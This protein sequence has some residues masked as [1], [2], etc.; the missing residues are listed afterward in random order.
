MLI[1]RFTYQE[2]V[3]FVHE[4]WRIH[5]L[6]WQAD[7]LYKF[8]GGGI[9]SYSL[10]TDHGKSMLLEMAAVI[11]NAEDPDRRFILVK[12]ND[13][14]AK[15]VCIEIC[16][17]LE[18]ISTELR[19]N[20]APLYPGSQPQVTWRGGTPWGVSKGFDV[21]GRDFRSRNI[22]P[23]IRSAS[24][25][26][27]DIQGKRGD[28]AV[29]DV[30]RLEEAES[31]AYR[32][33]LKTH[34]EGIFRTLEDKPDALWL[35]VGTPFHGDSIYDYVTRRLDGL[36]VEHER[37]VRP[38]KNEDGSFL[39]EERARKSEI[40]RKLMGKTAYAAAY[41]LRPVTGEPLTKEQVRDLVRDPSLPRI[42]NQ[43]QLVQVLRAWAMQTPVP[44]AFSYQR[45]IDLSLE[46]ELALY[47]C[48]DP[49]T[50]GD[51]ACGTVAIWGEDIFVLRGQVSV[52]DTWDQLLAVEDCYLPFPSSE[53]VVE[54]NGQQKAFKELAEQN[55]GLSKTQIH[56]HGTGSNKHD[57]R[58]G[59]PALIATVKQGFLHCSWADPAWAELEYDDLEEELISYGATSHPH[60]LMAIWFAWRRHRKLFAREGAR[61]KMENQRVLR[62]TGRVKIEIPRPQVTLPGPGAALRASTR[63]AWHRRHTS[64]R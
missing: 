41:E 13:D 14:A 20:G 18:F 16:R 34:I 19:Q 31:E 21:V 27:R 42:E 1:R 11:R 38:L 56:V 39:W 6:P 4:V 24:V 7:D 5:L 62:E 58:V 61:R 25:G 45:S 37:I 10:P 44:D 52:G 28:T 60:L 47:V 15:E 51:W 30:E 12:I 29:D 57:H 23:S 32:R 9:F 8:V 49:A 46:R 22:N 35:I 33:Q 17:R 63:A 64:Q 50:S 3:D 54:T 48:W 40:H 26:S 36:D 59:L 55:P 43:R 2:M 53:L